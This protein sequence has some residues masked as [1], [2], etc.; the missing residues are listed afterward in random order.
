M[1]NGLVRRDGEWCMCVAWF[2]STTFHKLHNNAIVFVEANLRTFVEKPCKRMCVFYKA[3]FLFD[4]VLIEIV[5]TRECQMVYIKNSHS[6]FF[7]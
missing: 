5:A 1:G 4:F 2:C 6:A 7:F 3:R